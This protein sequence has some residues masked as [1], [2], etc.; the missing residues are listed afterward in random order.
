MQHD[1]RHSRADVAPLHDHREHLTLLQPRRLQV[2]RRPACSL[3]ASCPAAP[4][5][6]APQPPKFRLPHFLF[7]LRSLELVYQ[8]PGEMLGIP[9]YRFVAPKTMFANGSEYEPNQGFC[10][11]RQSGLLNVSTCRHSESALAGASKVD[12]YSLRASRVLKMRVQE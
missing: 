1:Q 5:R 4:N 2:S 7:P 10:P 11:C 3:G 9:L 8:R 12:K 6:P